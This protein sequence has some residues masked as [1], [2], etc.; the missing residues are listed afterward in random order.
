MATTAKNNPTPKVVILGA[1]GIG[2]A[3]ALLLR[4]LGDVRP[5]LYLVDL[6][7]DALARAARVSG[8]GA[9]AGL[10]ETIAASPAE[11]TGELRAACRAADLILDCLPG[12][13]AF[14]SAQ[15]ALE[16]RTHYA[17]LTEFVDQTGKIAAL[18]AGAETAF[19]LQCGLA[20][21]F[22]DILAMDLVRDLERNEGVTTFE[23]VEMRVGALGRHAAHPHFYGFTWSTE[24]VATEYVEP[25]VV[26]RDF[27]RTTR[28]SLS[29]RR[30]LRVDG[31]VYEEALTSGGAADLPEALAGRVRTLDYKTLRYPGHYAWVESVLAGLP[32]GVDR[33]RALQ[34]R[35]EEAVPHIEDDEVVV[36][37]AVEGRVGRALR[38]SEASYRIRPLEIAGVRLR[39][40]QATTA[41]PLAEVARIL[42]AGGH[43]GVLTQSRVPGEFLSGPFVSAVYG[44]PPR[45]RLEAPTP[46]DP[47]PS[48]VST[49]CPA[50][51]PA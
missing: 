8:G 34:A 6:R 16:H 25:A 2:E 13:L 17:N 3:V 49:A 37:A 31:A 29:D 23:T 30:L 20:P 21:G 43:R 15:L 24:G 42:L 46:I 19:A 47:A 40:I 32:E 44:P 4:H 39:A 18:A 9:A 5:D 11:P 45:H 51:V 26:I 12:S 7:P 35:M 38:R 10:V 41:A 48:P 1:G 33:A 50:G 14:R 36:Y 22:V 27:Q 28:P